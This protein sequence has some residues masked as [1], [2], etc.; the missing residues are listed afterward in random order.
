MQSANSEVDET[1]GLVWNVPLLISEIM[2]YVQ[3]HI[4]CQHIYNIL[5]DRPFD[6]FT[7]SVVQNYSSEDQSITMQ[8]LHCDC[9]YFPAQFAPLY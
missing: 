2:L 7:D 6:I 3:V 8:W 1:L 4:V 9:P 5:L